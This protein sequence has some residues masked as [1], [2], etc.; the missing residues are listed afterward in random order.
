MRFSRAFRTIAVSSNY[1][2]YPLNRPHPNPSPV[3]GEGTWGI[4]ARWKIGKP[5]DSGRR[6]DSSTDHAADVGIHSILIENRD[7][8]GQGR[9]RGGFLTI[10]API[11]S[12]ANEAPEERSAI[13]PQTP[14][15][16]INAVR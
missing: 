12:S 1:R 16:S 5:D 8:P 7:V 11:G 15:H 4:V 3:S 10:D 2:K 13:L 14:E 6:A 9:E